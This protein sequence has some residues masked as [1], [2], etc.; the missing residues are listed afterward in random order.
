MTF[1]FA[2]FGPETSLPLASGIVAVAGFALM[3]GRKSFQFL[4]RR[5]RAVARWLV[6]S[7]P[8]FVAGRPSRKITGSPP[9]DHSPGLDR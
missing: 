6:R 9:R 7:E 2:Y 3:M 5:V 4:G 8:R 1:L